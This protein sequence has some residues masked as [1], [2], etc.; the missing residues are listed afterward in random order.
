MRVYVFVSA[1]YAELLAFTVAVHAQGDVPSAKLFIGRST[2]WGTAATTPPDSRAQVEPAAPVDQE[3]IR[4]KLHAEELDE[5]ADPDVKDLADRMNVDA[6]DIEGVKDVTVHWRKAFL[7][8]GLF[9]ALM[10]AK[11]AALEPSTQAGL[12][13]PFFKDYWRSIKGSLKW[14]WGDGDDFFINY[15]RHPAEGATFGFTMRQ[16]DPNSTDPASCGFSKKY[17]KQTF[18]TVIFSAIEST[19]FEIGPVSEASIGNVG[20]FKESGLVDFFVTPTV[21]VVFVIGQD[22]L[23]NY[24]VKKLERKI[25]NKI[26]SATI[27]AVL[28]PSRSLA[29]AVA[30]KKPWYRKRDKLKGNVCDH[31]GL[32][33]EQKI[34]ST[35]FGLAES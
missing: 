6:A 25:H 28:N 27:R 32:H 26:L 4:E 20:Y 5:M 14:K 29:N 3:K 10:N 7:E 15:V 11:R 2:M 22:L 19:L 33:S 12:K 9:I 17:F 30:F 16:N 35:E 23:D 34:G 1:L 24:V 31:L 13:G 18:K 21:G 8:S